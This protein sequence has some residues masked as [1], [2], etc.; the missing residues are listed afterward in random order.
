VT[1]LFVAKSILW[2]LVGIVGVVMLDVAASPSPADE[3]F[4]WGQF[5]A[6]TRHA[7]VATVYAKLGKWAGG[8]RR[9][10]REEQVSR[11]APLYRPTAIGRRLVL[12]SCDANDAFMAN[13]LW[14]V[15]SAQCLA[16]ADVIRARSVNQ[17]AHM[18][19]ASWA[20]CEAAGI[21][22]AYDMVGDARLPTPRPAPRDDEIG[23]RR[24]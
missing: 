5:P 2:A 24:A 11:D 3:S 6:C 23:G 7:I 12:L 17:R 18:R 15:F 20:E 9:I 14:T 10:P 4:L 19:G 13:P 21:L 16:Q 8:W 1:L 22:D